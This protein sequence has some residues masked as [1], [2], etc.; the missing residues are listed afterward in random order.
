VASRQGA[1]QEPQ[2]AGGWVLEN[3]E[4]VQV[5]EGGVEGE[6]EGGERETMA[7]PTDKLWGRVNLCFLQAE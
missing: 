7:R 6:G 5:A 4:D 1:P 2:V 3:E